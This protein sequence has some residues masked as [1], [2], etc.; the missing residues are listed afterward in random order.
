MLKI[1]FLSQRTADCFFVSSG[2]FPDA[3]HILIDGGLSKDKKLLIG[4]VQSHIEAGNRIDL[5][6]LTHVD[7]D[8]IGGFLELFKKDFITSSVIGEVWFNIKQDSDAATNS[9][10][11]LDVSFS[12]GSRLAETLRGKYIPI[13]AACADR[14]PPDFRRKDCTVEVIAPSCAALESLQQDWALQSK[15]DVAADKADHDLSWEQLREEKFSEDGS[16]KNRSSIA[17]IVRSLSAKKSVLFC[18]DS[19]PSELLASVDSS[20]EQFDLVK[21]PHHGSRANTNSKLLEKFPTKR[22]V[23]SAGSNNHKPHKKTLQ[24]LLDSLTHPFI[25]YVPKGNWIAKKM[26]GHLSG[27]GCKIVEYQVGLSLEL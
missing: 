19:V 14:D 3:V 10:S 24:L 2:V 27:S 25:I 1:T 16:V 15:L 5:V 20:P 11:N 8:H 23:I 12:Q 7:G 17:V 21:L 22:Y 13:R 9:V 6:V 4:H 18:G 26:T